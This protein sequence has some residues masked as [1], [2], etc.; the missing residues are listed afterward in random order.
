[1]LLLFL[2]S[3]ILSRFLCLKSTLHMQTLDFWLG[4]LSKFMQLSNLVEEE[5]K[6]RKMVV[7]GCLMLTL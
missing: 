6:S 4:T 5:S 7:F 2:F 1:M 3:R